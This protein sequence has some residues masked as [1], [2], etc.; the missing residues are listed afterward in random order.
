MSDWANYVAAG[1]GVFFVVALALL[2]SGCRAALRA[3]RNKASI[4][5]AAAPWLFACFS[6]VFVRHWA[7]EQ[8]VFRAPT[9]LVQQHAEKIPETVKKLQGWNDWVFHNAILLGIPAAFLLGFLFHMFTS[10]TMRWVFRIPFIL[11]AGVGLL[12]LH[13]IMTKQADGVAEAAGNLWGS[14]RK[15]L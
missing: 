15:L 13:Q 2:V 3:R 4:G 5:K 7:M 9:D 10:F 6:L 12:I 8:D 11:A 14:V 1:E